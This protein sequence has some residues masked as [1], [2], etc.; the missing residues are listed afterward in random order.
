MLYADYPLTPD[1]I[2]VLPPSHEVVVVVQFGVLTAEP[3]F[4]AR[5]DN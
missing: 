5:I 2:D 3:H 1:Q 4:F